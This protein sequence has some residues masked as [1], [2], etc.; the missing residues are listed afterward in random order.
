MGFWD[1]AEALMVEHLGDMPRWHIAGFYALTL[2]LGLVTR[3]FAPVWMVN[4]VLILLT[5]LLVMSLVIA[6]RAVTGRSKGNSNGT[7]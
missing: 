5:A 3:Y 4:T 2:A 7:S 1:R 6:W